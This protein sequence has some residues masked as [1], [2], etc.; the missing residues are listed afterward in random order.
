MLFILSTPKLNVIFQNKGAMSDVDV[1]ALDMY[2]NLTSTNTQLF[3][4]TVEYHGE[5]EG[6]DDFE[7]MQMWIEALTTFASIVLDAYASTCW[8]LLSIDVFI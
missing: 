8:L 6:K 7:S 1:E 5:V 3:I 2:F 4:R